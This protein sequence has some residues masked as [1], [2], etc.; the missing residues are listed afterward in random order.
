MAQ[1]EG[2]LTVTVMI[3]E[4]TRSPMTVSV[5]APESVGGPTINAEAGKTPWSELVAVTVSADGI[6][7]PLIVKSIIVESLSLTD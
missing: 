1:F 3:V 2:S 6:T 5:R 4:P 7:L